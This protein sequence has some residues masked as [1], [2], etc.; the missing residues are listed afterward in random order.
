[1]KVFEGCI[2]FTLIDIVFIPSP[3]LKVEVV[4]G[5]ERDDD[6]SDI[7]HHDDHQSEHSDQDQGHVDHEEGQLILP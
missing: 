4:D 1:M 7:D 3:Y 2:N 5:L 6:Q